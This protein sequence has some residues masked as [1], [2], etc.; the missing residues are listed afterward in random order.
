MIITV[1]TDTY[2]S[3]ADADSYW[4]A[5]GV[6]TWIDATTD[7][8]EAA[9][10]E[11]TQYIDT[12]YSFIGHV[13]SDAVLAWPRYCATVL[14]GNLA[15]VTYDSATIPPQ[16]EAACAELAMEALGGRLR[17]ALPRAGRVKREK[18]DVLEVEY[19]DEA[20]AHTSYD[21][22]A[23]LLSPLL[24]QMPGSVRAVRA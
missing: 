19:A 2:L 9:L 20:P 5:R 12:A 3:V 10:L 6:A 22:V 1:G 16:V 8:K 4:A 23:M 14:Y 17:P 21:F 11:A 13:A 7:Q 15:G 18:V 24:A